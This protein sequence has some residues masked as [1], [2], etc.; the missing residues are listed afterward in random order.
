MYPNRSKEH[1]FLNII[2][3]NVLLFHACFPY[4]IHLHKSMGFVHVEILQYHDEDHGIHHPDRHYQAESRNHSACR[5]HLPS[6]GPLICSNTFYLIIYN[7]A[8]IDDT[9]GPFIST[10]SIHHSTTPVTLQRHRR[11]SIQISLDLLTA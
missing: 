11:Q 8:I 4:A 10:L 9:I 2:F 5:V 3:S 1:F 6:I 7:C